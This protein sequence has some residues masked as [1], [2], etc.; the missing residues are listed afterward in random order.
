VS[1]PDRT[2][3][4]RSTVLTGTAVEAKLADN[5]TRGQHNNFYSLRLAEP[6]K[7]YRAWPDTFDVGYLQISS[8]RHPKTLSSR[9]H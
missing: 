1:K 4:R 2:M 6:S 8:W 9:T 5:M 3:R 7:V